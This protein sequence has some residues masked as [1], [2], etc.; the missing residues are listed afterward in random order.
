MPRPRV[1]D[2]DRVLAAVESLAARSGPAAVT[3]RAVSEATGAS[4]G[5]VYHGFGSRAA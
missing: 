5:A 3:I 4:N 1:H 2:P